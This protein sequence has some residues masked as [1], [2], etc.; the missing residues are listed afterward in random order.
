MKQ[1][2]YITFKNGCIHRNSYAVVQASNIRRVFE[3]SSLF[4][5]LSN[6]YT[7][8]QWA[9]KTFPTQELQQINSTEDLP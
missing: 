6:I 5:G 7:E 8:E 9:T 3:Y 4:P 1:R 2:F